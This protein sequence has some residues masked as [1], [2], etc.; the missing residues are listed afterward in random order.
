MSLSRGG[1]LSL[2]LALSLMGLIL[3]TRKGAKSRLWLA[4]ATVALSLTA[5]LWLGGE[6]ILARLST[7]LGVLEDPGSNIRTEVWKDALTIVRDH[8]LFGTGFGTF[9]DIYPK[10]KTVDTPLHFIH[11]HN[12]HL[13][14]LVEGGI[15]G[16]ATMA[17][18]A[19]IFYKKATR[20][21][22]NR[23]DQEVVY[24]GLGGLFAITAFLFHSTTTF[25]HHIPANALYFTVI[26][27]L[28]LKTLHSKS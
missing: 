3:G 2:L 22:T 28:T 5:A 26:A 27:A 16:F 9:S 6:T 25:N 21:I 20:M 8:P 7:L 10:Y 18:A 19:T 15:I 24:L 13:Q 1:M 14:L 12:D 4:A 23:R 11:T 17:L